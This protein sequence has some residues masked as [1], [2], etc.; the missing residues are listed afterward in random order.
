[1]AVFSSVLCYPFY[2]YALTWI[3]VSRVSA[4]AY[5]QPLLATLIAIPTLGEYPTDSL[6]AGGA[7]VLTGVFMAERL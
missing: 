6:V 7:V 3:P 1:M 2:Y 5:F 4:L